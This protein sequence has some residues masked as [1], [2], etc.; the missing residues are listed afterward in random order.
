MGGFGGEG[1]DTPGAQ[2]FSGKDGF[3][4]INACM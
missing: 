1:A 3:V 2:G 4:I